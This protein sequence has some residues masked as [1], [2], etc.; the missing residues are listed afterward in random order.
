MEFAKLVEVE[1]QKISIYLCCN[2]WIWS[3]QWHIITTCSVWGQAN[4]ACKQETR[5]QK[6]MQGHNGE[7]S[8]PASRLGLCC[9]APQSGCFPDLHSSNLSH[10]V[11]QS[12]CIWSRAVAEA[13]FRL[14]S[15]EQLNRGVKPATILPSPRNTEQWQQAAELGHR[16]TRA[17]LSKTSG[18][19]QRKITGETELT[20]S[21]MSRKAIRALPN[22]QKYQHLTFLF[23][24]LMH[25]LNPDSMQVT[26]SIEKRKM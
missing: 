7:A 5:K 26:W 24:F 6:Q 15:K 19:V 4:K 18:Q 10:R 12:S 3:Y 22:L 20:G 1:V 25:L 14:Q 11:A 2:T 23:S 13:L 8:G 9:P 16:G 17:L 21:C